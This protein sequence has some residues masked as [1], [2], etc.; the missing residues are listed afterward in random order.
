MAGMGVELVGAIVGL[1]AIGYLIDRWLGSMP[2]G[3]IIGL[4]LGVLGGGYAFLRK[5]LAFSQDLSDIRKKA[6]L[7]PL[8]D[9]DTDQISSEIT[10]RN[11]PPWQRTGSAGRGWF[12]RT[13]VDLPED[14]EDL[15]DD[16][17]KFPKDF[18]DDLSDF[19]PNPTDL[20]DDPKDPSSP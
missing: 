19:P 2:I 9:P 6:P 3:T 16:Q 20:P 15:S 4:I 17:P 11:L 14:D 5:A 1:G 18:E 7:K 8:V 10:P 13:T 12:D